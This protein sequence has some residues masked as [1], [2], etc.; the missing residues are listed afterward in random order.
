SAS[1]ALTWTLCILT[2]L[3]SP[4][5]L[6]AIGCLPAA[7][8]RGFQTRL[9]LKIDA[10]CRQ[11]SQTTVLGSCDASPDGESGRGVDPPPSRRI[12]SL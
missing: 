6:P 8:W 2:L 4:E 7:V 1:R 10:A 3:C 11:I 12:S 9:Y 5:F